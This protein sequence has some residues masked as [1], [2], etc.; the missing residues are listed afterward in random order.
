[1]NA[2]VLV[3]SFGLGLIVLDTSVRTESRLRASDG[4]WR[5]LAFERVESEWYKSIERMFHGAE[6]VVTGRMTEVR[7][8]R[9]YGTAADA[10]VVR[11][12]VIDVRIEHAYKGSLDG[13]E[14]IQ[15]EVTLPAGA[16]ASWLDSNIDT[17]PAIFFLRSKGTEARSLGW[18]EALAAVED[19]YFRLVSSQ[20]LIR[21]I[22]G[23]AYPPIDAEDAFLI[24]V[25]G[26]SLEFVER[27][28]TSAE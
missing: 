17:S 26:R 2:A 7:N 4:F 8:S 27:Q 13:A 12:A 10:A 6:L 20:G 21:L 16:S 28:M 14:S 24:A 23:V 5:T 3:L 1:M 19:R 9:T 18:S 22:D 15:L 25:T 11:L